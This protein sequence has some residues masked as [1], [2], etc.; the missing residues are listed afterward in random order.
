MTNL[1]NLNA[2][3]TGFQKDIR[4]DGKTDG[5]T[6]SAISICH[7]TGGIT[8]VIPQHYENFFR[9]MSKAKKQELCPDHTDVAT[10]LQQS[11]NILHRD[12]KDENIKLIDFGAVAILKPGKL[13]STY[14]GTLEYCSPEVLIGNK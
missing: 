1:R 10:S 9:S 8:N 4:M 14:C 13:F 5:Q 12:I 2:S 3:V 7:P 11:K 6:D